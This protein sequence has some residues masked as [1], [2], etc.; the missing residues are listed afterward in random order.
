MQCFRPVTAYQPLEGGRVSFF[1]RKDSRTVTI[2]CGGCIG[3]RIARQ[4]AW[5]VRCY[6]ESKMH[7]RNAFITLTYNEENYPQYGSLNYR[8]WQLFAKRLRK[9]CG[10]FR[11]FMCGEYGDDL[12]RPHFHALLFGRGFDDMRML[13][14]LRGQPIFTSR[15]LD[16][17][18]GKGFASIGE[19]NYAT[20]AYT[21]GY[22]IKVVKGNKADDH[23]ARVDPISGEITSL[24]PE[25]C[26][27]SLKPGIGDGYIQ[28]YHEL[29]YLDGMRIQGKRKGI[30]TYFDDT[31]RVLFPE[32]MDEVEYDRYLKRQTKLADNT[33]ER[34]AVKEEVAWAEY[35]FYKERRDAL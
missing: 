6:A 35:H 19:V 31:M 25:F 34:L 1:E 22:C 33:P 28:K 32:I 11:F 17:V 18:W 14:R 8:D 15:T 3:C 27:M 13:K 21:A 4:Q 9:K 30:P 29:V 7:E 26:G 5:A 2:R 23:Y 12:Q 20:A 24:E 16:E 10:P